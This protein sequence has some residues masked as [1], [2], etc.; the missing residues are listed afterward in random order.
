MMEM[1][2]MK[3]NNVFNKDE[4]KLLIALSLKTIRLERAKTQ[5]E[6]AEAIGLNLQTYSA[7]ER[8]RNEI[9]AEYLVRLSYYYDM[10]LDIL[11]QR[12]NRCRDAVTANYEIN[13]AGKLIENLKNAM[14]D[15]KLT[16]H[17]DDYTKHQINELLNEMK[18]L[19]FHLGEIFKKADE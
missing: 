15:E 12:D 18:S 11:M 16:D 2:I 4:R 3:Y 8:G 1:P 5:K 13:E 9:P 7:Y 10:P 19:N 6:V 17:I 14:L